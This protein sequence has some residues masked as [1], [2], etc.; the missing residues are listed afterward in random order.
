MKWSRLAAAQGDAYAQYNLGFMY[1]RGQGIAQNYVRAHMFFLLSA[2]NGY[3]DASKNRDAVA[4]RMT[5]AQ[6]AQAQEMTHSG[7]GRFK[8]CD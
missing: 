5:A 4:K 6:I 7:C 3:P 2:S 1:E 8:L